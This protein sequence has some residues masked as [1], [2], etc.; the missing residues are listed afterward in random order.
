MPNLF[1]VFP[2]FISSDSIFQKMVDLGAPWTSQQGLSMDLS[3]FTMY[4][5]LKTASGFT[6]LNVSSE[7]SINSQQI[8]KILWDIYGKN[9]KRLWDAYVIEY[10]PIDNYNVMESI[11]R[12]QTNNR[13]IGKNGSLSSSVDGTVSQ[14]ESSKEVSELE[15]GHK[16][17]NTENSTQNTKESGTS[18]LEHGEGISTD[19][20][21]HSFN[22]GFNSSTHVPI[23]D[24]LNSGTQTHSGT[25][26]TTTIGTSDIINENTVSQINSGSDVTTTDISGSSDVATKNVRADTTEENTTDDDT[27]QET[28][29]RKRS[30]NIGQNSYQDLLEKEFE[31][32]KWNFFW[33]VFEDVDKYLCL[34]VFDGCSSVN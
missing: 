26:T 19:G 6:M 10:N 34:S 4:S 13:V 27:I 30:G 5:G 12:D 8:A 7:G 28:I 17:D 32:W 16:V 21:A 18:S 23:A 11:T 31:I 25:D 20:E 1:T 33:N 2:D 14:T 3:Y 9:W 22:Y 29:S 15:H 24:Q